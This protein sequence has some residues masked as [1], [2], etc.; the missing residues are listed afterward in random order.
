MSWIIVIII[1]LSILFKG[2]YVFLAPQGVKEIAKK[3]A[4]MSNWKLKLMGLV[5]MII[6]IL[7]YFM[8]LVERYGYYGL[9][10]LKFW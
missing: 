8:G 7:L 6:G 1:G 4:K 10:S 5:A 3:Y 2:L 9:G